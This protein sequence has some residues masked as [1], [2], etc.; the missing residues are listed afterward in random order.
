MARFLAA[1]KR[2]NPERF[3]RVCAS[4]PVLTRYGWRQIFA[5]E[6]LDDFA[7]RWLVP[8]MRSRMPA[9]SECYAQP[10]AESA[11]G[12]GES[13]APERPSEPAP[14]GPPAP[15]QPQTV[16]PMIDYGSEAEESQKSANSDQAEKRG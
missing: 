13:P 6:V 9:P 15:N 10:V 12:A 3:K 5:H 7:Q 2:R 14:Q 4:A 11:D 1:A 8:W 16:R